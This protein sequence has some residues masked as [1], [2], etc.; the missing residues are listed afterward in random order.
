M[1]SIYI[2]G[3][4]IVAP[5]LIAQDLIDQNK[6][7]SILRGEEDWYAEPLPKLVPNM[8]PANERRRTTQVINIAL[9]TIQPLLHKND[10][11]DETAT[12][13]ASSDGDL[14]IE[15]KIC[16]ALSQIEK[17]VSPTHFHNSVHNAPAGYWAIA[18]SMRAESISISAGDGTFS[19]GL[20]DAIT[21]VVNEQKTVLLVAYDAVAP[22]PLDAKRHFAHSI[23]IALRLGTKAEQ[24]YIGKISISI[25]TNNSNDT[26]CQNKSLEPL[27]LSNPIGLGIPLLEALV[28]NASTS[29][30]IPYIMEQHLVVK[31]N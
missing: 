13:F 24:G 12:I 8:L 21:Q 18:A 1:K 25:D 23:A 2:N 10:D 9:Q 6:S 28:R 31:V 16:T 19:A 11:L 3:L 14:V 5:G 4:S 17:I 7:F 30:N 27:R 22:E 20:I 26:P 29:V 15:D